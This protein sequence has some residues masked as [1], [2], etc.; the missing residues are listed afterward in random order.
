MENW[1]NQQCVT[2]C[3]R[4][5]RGHPPS[6]SWDARSTHHPPAE[7]TDLNNPLLA[8]FHPLFKSRRFQ[9]ECASQQLRRDY[10]RMRSVNSKW[11]PIWAYGH[12]A[13]QMGGEQQILTTPPSAP[14]GLR[15]AIAFASPTDFP[16]SKICVRIATAICHWLCCWSKSERGASEARSGPVGLWA[17]LSGC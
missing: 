7:A 15:P 12:P 11:V 17:L 8:L 13:K 2:S 6:P 10:Q 14:N 5:S 3:Q 16:C 9:V 1:D 4:A